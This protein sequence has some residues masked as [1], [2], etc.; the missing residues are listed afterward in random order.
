MIAEGGSCR[1]NI[2][3]ELRFVEGFLS[4]G[5][6]LLRNYIVDGLFHLIIFFIYRKYNLF[7]FELPQTKNK[8]GK[9]KNI[10]GQIS[11]ILE[12]LM[13]ETHSEGFLLF[14]FLKIT[15]TNPLDG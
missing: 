15:I 8:I 5:S 11:I 12:F 7:I 2:G 1:F 14:E 6:V 4:R 10:G 13:Q 9:R 3:R